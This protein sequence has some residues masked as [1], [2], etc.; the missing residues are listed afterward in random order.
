[1]IRTGTFAACVL[2]VLSVEQAQRLSVQEVVEQAQEAA[3]R[4]RQIAADAHALA[5]KAKVAA[6]IANEQ[7]DIHSKMRR[8]NERGLAALGD[9]QRKGQYRTVTF[10]NGDTYAGENWWEDAPDGSER[11]RSPVLGV[12][13]SVNG[14]RYAGQISFTA[15]GDEAP[16]GLIED[17]E[18]N[19]DDYTGETHGG[20]FDGF[21]LWHFNSNPTLGPIQFTGDYHQGNVHYGVMQLGRS[22]TQMVG[23]FINGTY[24]WLGTEIV[25]GRPN[26]SGCFEGLHLVDDAPCQRAR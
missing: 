5:D 22:G 6:D 19:G 9:S 10:R 24:L 14:N 7:D 26:A 3:T 2:S 8:L 23:W 1:M 15:M 16:G 21:G 11:L 12:Y 20:T 17:V 13:V 18:V 25:P 4:A